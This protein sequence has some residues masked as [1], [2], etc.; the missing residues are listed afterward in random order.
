[1]HRDVWSAVDIGQG[2]RRSLL[3]DRHDDRQAV[4]PEARHSRSHGVNATRC[5]EMRL[6][7][8]LQH[9]RAAI[10]EPEPGRV[11]AGTDLDTGAVTTFT[12][13]PYA[14]GRQTLVTI[15]TTTTVRDG[16]PGRI[17]GWL[18]TRLLRPIYERELAQLAAVAALPRAP[19]AGS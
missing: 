8:R 18:T 7:G 1:M 17:A 6:L 15:T 9:F 5:F 3:A 2:S 19:S 4:G 16:L 12:G 14:D 10:S 11:L 13:A